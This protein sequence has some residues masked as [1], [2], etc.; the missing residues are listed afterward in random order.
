M[1]R[2]LL[3]WW[4]DPTGHDHGLRHL[5]SLSAIVA[6][7][8][9]AF[10]F[11]PA[12]DQGQAVE[13]SELEY[14]VWLTVDLARADSAADEGD[15]VARLEEDFG[16]RDTAKAA[17]ELYLSVR[18]RLDNAPAG[19][20]LAPPQDINLARLRVMRE[21][22]EKAS[23]ARRPVMTPEEIIRYSLRRSQELGFSPAD[24]WARRQGSRKLADEKAA[25]E[26]IVVELRDQGAT[27][28][29]IG[30]IFGGRTKQSVEAL[31]RAG[32]QLLSEE[33]GK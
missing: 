18:T 13:V 15:L 33:G 16:T 25:R 2:K 12:A 8:L 30:A 31:E 3:E 20:V 32:R 27:R 5:P 4:Q 22:L 17:F 21:R 19:A 7:E 28:P 11:E 24:I 1:D 23:Q 10:G 9:E 29:D 26:R 14:A 6:A